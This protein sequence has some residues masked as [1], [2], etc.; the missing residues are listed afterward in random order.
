MPQGSRMGRFGLK[1]TASASP[2]RPPMRHARYGSVLAAAARPS[3]TARKADAM[4]SPMATGRSPDLDDEEISG[5]HG[6]DGRRTMSP[7]CRSKPVEAKP[8][9]ERLLAGDGLR[10]LPCARTHGMR[11]NH[12][13]SSPICFCMIWAPSWPARFAIF[14]HGERM[15]HRPADR[16]GC[17]PGQETLS[18]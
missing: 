17:A 9:G 16:S 6:R 5:D 15:A 3:A 13:R 7:P 14:R 11:A 4:L 12:F 1:A 18:A 2:I 10:L 8:Q